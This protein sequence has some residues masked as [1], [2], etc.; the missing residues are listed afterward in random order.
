MFSCSEKK[1]FLTKQ[2]GRVK[3]W[4]RRWFVLSN[5]CKSNCFSKK[6]L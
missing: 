2:G 6:C 1:G 4:K 3:T 5:N